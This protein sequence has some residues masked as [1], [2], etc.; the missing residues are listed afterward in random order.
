MGG[1]CS[2]VGGIVRT[3][4]AKLLGMTM[5]DL[6]SSIDSE[7]V[8]LQQVRALLAGTGSRTVK[9]GRSVKKKHTVSAAGRAAIAAAQRKRWAKQ[10]KAAKKG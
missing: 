4:C 1:S 9:R 10:K 5:N 2:L 8:R 6:L 7:I 3:L